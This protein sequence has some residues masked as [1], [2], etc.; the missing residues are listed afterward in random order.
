MFSKKGI[1]NKIVCFFEKYPKHYYVFAF[2]VIFFSIIT[3]KVFSYTVLNYSFYK[4]LADKQQIWKVSI[5]VTRWNI[6]SSVNGWTILATSVN[7]NDLAIDPMIKW[8]KKALANFLKDILYKQICYLKTDK[9]CYDWISKFIK[10]LEITDFEYNEVYEKKI[11]LDYLYKKIQRTKVRSVLV[12]KELDSEKIT[13]IES[14]K[15][16][17]VYISWNALYINPE[18]II[19]TDLVS[20]KIS[21]IIWWNIADF[22]HYIRKRDLRYIPIYN[23]ISITISE[24]IK[25]YL[26]E[27]KYAIKKWILNKSKSFW[28]FIILKPN[29]H[30][31]YPEN[32]IASQI[33]WFTDS[34]WNWHYWIE[35]EFNLT[36]RWQKSFVKSK[37]DINGRVID[38]FSLWK[39]S[40]TMKGVDIYTTI[41][42]NIQKKA[43]KL[44]K[45]WVIKYRANK[46]S[47][48]ILEPK[49]WKIIAM[50]NYPSYNPNNPWYV[51]ELE[52]INYV[53][54]PNLETD[55]LGM[56]ILVEDIERWKEFLYNSKKIYLRMANK[57]DLSDYSLTKYKY[58]NNYWAGVY[59][60]DIISSLYEPGSIMKAVTVSIWI[61]TQEINKYSMY[62]DKWELDID[63]FKIKN[64]SRK[65]LGY[66]SFGHALNYSCNVWMIRIAQRYWKALAYEYLK[67]FWFSENTW[68]SLDWEV[69]SKLENYE[70]WSRAKLFTSSYWLGISVTPLQMATAYSVIANWWVYIVPRIID[71]IV[72]PNGKIIKYKPELL[73]RVIKKS[74]SDTM[75]KMLVSSIEN[76]VA[77]HWKVEWYTLAW[78]TWTSPIATKWK[79]EKWVGTTIASFAW[80]WPAEDPKF[81]IIIKLDR[82]RTVQYW[83]NSS[84]FIYKDM[85][86]YL[87]DYLGIPKKIKK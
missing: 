38:P 19:N 76:W 78:K 14:Y 20:E 86:W 29:P 5:P 87:L 33:V 81:V 32:N 74:T 9:E 55:L 23:K 61:D 73:R 6:Y 56:P 18:E 42:R 41:D 45:D 52:K 50:A 28:W 80:F 47:M 83:W 25:K 26:S 36:L 15:F 69:S 46:W 48:V 2:F 24:E 8:D 57:A 30:R 37:K 12:E 3:L 44:I 85:A 31:F 49:T 17:W 75:I 71:H 53:K 70:K 10:V 22:K 82:P 65:C 51:Y 21:K 77:W 84:A 39:D 34:A 72:Y 62:M 43:E 16:K 7:L 35:W 27:E 11:I 79:Y 58:K 64:V 67:N 66:H 1:L 68:I 60:N 40:S 13:L 4:N 59:K 63:T 54:Y